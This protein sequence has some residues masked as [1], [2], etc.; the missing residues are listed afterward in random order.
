MVLRKLHPGCLE[1]SDA[2]PRLVVSV[3]PSWSRAAF[4]PSLTF[5]ELDLH[6]ALLGRGLAASLF[7][8][9]IPGTEALPFPPGS[10]S[11]KSNCRNQ[12]DDGDLQGEAGI[13][14]TLSMLSVAVSSG[15]SPF[16]PPECL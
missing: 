12:E 1:Q 2:A 7:P 14:L 16:K 8:P 5:E 4:P 3:G 6:T 13:G 10:E 9:I 15:V 11:R